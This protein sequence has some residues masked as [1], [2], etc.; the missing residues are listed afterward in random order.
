VSKVWVIL[1][2]DGRAI[3]ILKNE[4]HAAQQPAGTPTGYKD[5]AL[6][7]EQIRKQVFVRDGYACTHCGAPVSWY[8]GQMHERVWRGRGGEIS[9]ANSTTLCADCHQKDPVA[10]HGSRAVQWGTGL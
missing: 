10:G 7:T 3:E 1:G 8:T 6:V 5:R 2:A 9:V 4:K